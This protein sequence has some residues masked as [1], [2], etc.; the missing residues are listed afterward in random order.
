MNA[1]KL[2]HAALHA[3]APAAPIERIVEDDSTGGPMAPGAVRLPIEDQLPAFDGATAW[4]NSP[5]LTPAGLRGKVVLVDFWTYTCINWL[6]TLPYVRAWADKYKDHGVAVVSVHTPEFPFEQDVANVRRAAEDMRV[7]YPIAVDG[8]YAVWRAF[9]NHYWPALYI[10][11]AQG[12]IRHHH[13]GEGAYARAEMVIQHLL[14]EAGRD[15]FDSALVS[16][17][18]RGIEAPAD[19]GS[20]ESPETYLGY[21]RA[22]NFATPGG[23]AWDTRHTYAAPARLRLNQWALAG[24]WTIEPQA[25]VLHQAGGR[26]A[27]R[28]HARDL[29]LV[30]APARD[31]PMRF[32][33]LLDGQAPGAAHGLDVDEQGHG[34]VTAPRLYQLIRQPLPIADRQCEITFLDAGVA[35]YVFTFG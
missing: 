35:A 33:V 9:N 14:A 21:E 12:R 7:A 25:A 30:L 23:A 29:H 6:R 24:E 1:H 20:L 2:W 31:T 32:R 4:L 10:V 28:F 13:F 15:G 18:G 17:E 34:T 27:Y 5:P 26:I 3:P 16:I 11:D 19:W 22:E 8:D